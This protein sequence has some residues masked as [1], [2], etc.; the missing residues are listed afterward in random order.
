ML[1]LEFVLG[2]HSM[3]TKSINNRL[4]AQQTSV[5]QCFP[6]ICV[7]NRGPTH[8]KGRDDNIVVG[9]FFGVVMTADLKILI[10]L[11][12]AFL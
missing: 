9:N 10:V 8:G 2:Q 1:R 12:D 11:R 7:A 4:P 5:L 3:Q 6:T